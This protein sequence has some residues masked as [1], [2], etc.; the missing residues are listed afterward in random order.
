MLNSECTSNMHP[1]PQPPQY[2]STSK[3]LTV[4]K[5]STSLDESRTLRSTSH[6]KPSFLRTRSLKAQPSGTGAADNGREDIRDLF[7]GDDAAS[8]EKHVTDAPP[9]TVVGITN[10]AYVNSGIYD[11]GWVFDE[12]SSECMRCDS[13]FNFFRRRH[14]CRSV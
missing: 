14:H 8:H 3:L 11:V 10:R 6:D 9:T 5:S 13:R 1:L 7:F 4:V 12:E 2:I